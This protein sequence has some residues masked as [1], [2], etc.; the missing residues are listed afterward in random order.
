MQY[1]HN[2]NGTKPLGTMYNLKRIRNEL[3]HSDPEKIKK[4]IRVENNG[5]FSFYFDTHPH[6]MLIECPPE[7]PFKPP[8]IF[9]TKTIIPDN[10]LDHI[11]VK[12]IQKIIF[13]FVGFE[14]KIHFKK[15]IYNE[16][17]DTDIDLACDLMTILDNLIIYDWRPVIKILDCMKTIE[18]EIFPHINLN[19][20]SKP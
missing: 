5:T 3:L 17:K 1:I 10:C 6:I 7:Y 19:Y 12:D 4:I 15:Y 18:N 14:Y 11:V 2:T 13:N 9:L 8:D 20:K 16:L